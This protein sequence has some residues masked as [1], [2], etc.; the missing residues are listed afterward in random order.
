MTPTSQAQVALHPLAAQIEVAVLQTDVLVDV[1]GAG[2]DRERRRIGGAQHL[3][4]AVADLHV[5]GREVRVD[6]ALGALPDGAGDPHD[7]LAAHVDRVVDDTL[8]DPR[9]VAHVDEGEV[10]AVLAAAG[11]PPAHDTVAPMSVE[12]SSPHRWVRI[13]VADVAGT[14]GKAT[15]AAW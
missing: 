13:E 3:D 9:V 15:S 2:V 10:L 6:R 7:V 14:T 8:D 4:G 11:D 1:V 12:R 5:A